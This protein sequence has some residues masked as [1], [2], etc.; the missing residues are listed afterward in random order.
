MR[1]L[2]TG[3]AAG[4]VVVA[5]ALLLAACGGAASPSASAS[6][7]DSAPEFVTEAATYQIVVDRPA[8]L[9]LALLTM[10]QQWVSFGTAQVQFAFIGDG[11]GTP[12]PGVTMPTATARF[13]PIPGSP[14]DT[15][16]P[17]AITFPSDGHGLYAAEDVVFPEVGIWQLL[18]TGELADGTA[19]A[20][21]TF[22][23]ALS[24]PTVPWVGDEAIA[25]DNAVIGDPGVPNSALDSRAS[26]DNPIPDPELH[27]VSIADAIAAGRPAL[28]VFSTPVYCV[29]QFCGP[30]TDVVADLA[31]EYGDRADFI[32]VEIYRDFEAEELNQAVLDWLVGPDGNFREPWVYLIDGEGTIIGSWDTMVTRDEIEPMLQALPAGS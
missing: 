29:S 23:Q 4:G 27:Q 1:D 18:A 12:P 10:D 8:R 15:G 7:G 19:V 31:A 9:L 14:P 11:T 28:V 2:R 32:H 16:Q 3:R 17:M 24:T 26:G 21:T 6:P 20:A 22:V 30:V 25:S 5:L 13:L